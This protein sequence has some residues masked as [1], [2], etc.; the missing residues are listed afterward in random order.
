VLKL[1]GLRIGP[2]TNSSSSH[3]V[4]F[5]PEDTPLPAEVGGGGKYGGDNFTLTSREEKQH[6]LDVQKD[7]PH[8]NDDYID[9]Q[10]KW[11]W[12]I[13]I[14]TG[15]PDKE[16]IESFTKSMAENDRIII[17]GGHDN[18]EDHP[19]RNQNLEI[20]LPRMIRW[21]G[22]RI[23]RE[24]WGWTLHEGNYVSAVM[25][26]QDDTFTDAMNIWRSSA[27]ELVDLKIT[28][29]CDYACDYC[30]QDATPDG[31]EASMNNITKIAEALRCAGVFEVA[32]G[33]GDPTTHS[34]LPDII[35]TFQDKGIVAN[36]SVK[37]M[38]DATKD[39]RDVMKSGTLGVTVTNLEEITKA[40]N[41]D[42]RFYSWVAHIV[43]GAQ[44]MKDFTEMMEYVGANYIRALLL[45]FKRTGR[46][47]TFTPHD[48]TG[49]EMVVASAF[50]AAK[51]KH[52]DEGDYDLPM[53][54]Y[55]RYPMLAVDTYFA[56][57]QQRILKSMGVPT[58]L[59]DTVE[60]NRSCYIDAVTMRL[61]PCSF[62]PDDDMHPITAN[63]GLT[64]QILSLFRKQKL[65]HPKMWVT[66]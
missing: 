23:R 46:G 26:L 54:P 11:S 20:A 12:P 39:V 53:Q 18:S 22:A 2:A 50:S 5:W 66:R 28:G 10:S 49:W 14:L 48:Y 41:G 63:A 1:I 52:E 58:Y 16:F 34:K 30:Y 29:K 64:N 65:M 57:E 24:P 51:D 43:M 36:V 8:S 7:K 13:N 3:S 56:A 6:Y 19:L 38:E 21:S 47:S 25:R 45:G 61:G 33:G 32:I 44:S 40:H 17:L 31:K 62:C 42:N 9:S 59:Y 55:M 37:R 4:I 35:T 60:G 27:P 15:Q